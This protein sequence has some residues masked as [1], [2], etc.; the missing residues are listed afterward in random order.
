MH[1]L[2]PR[3][4]HEDLEH[5]TRLRQRRYL[6]RVEL[7]RQEAA[8]R[9]LCVARADPGAPEVRAQRRLD[10]RQ[11]LTQHAVLA[12]V[13]HLVERLLDGAYLTGCRRVIALSG[14]EAQ[15]EQACQHACDARVRRQ[16]GLDVRLRQREPDLPQVLRVGAQDRDLV[17]SEPCLQDQSVEVVVLDAALEHARKRVFEQRREGPDI[18]LV[19]CRHVELEVVN[20]HRFGAVGRDCVGPF[21]QHAHAHVLEHRQRIRQRHR[22]TAAVDLEAET[23]G[24]ASS[25]SIEVEHELGACQALESLYI[26][27]GADRV[28]MFAVGRRECG[29]VAPQKLRGVHLLDRSFRAERRSSSQRRAVAASCASSARRSYDRDASRSRAHG[30]VDARQY[31]RRS[32]ARR[33]RPRSR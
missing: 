18:D 16:R 33:I 22:R 27:D 7:E 31:R 15:P 1:A 23:V 28:D 29:S 13:R 3:G 4:V 6:L 8:T 11:Q 19:A 21:G 9:T 17:G 26:L 12:R 10:Q 32:A 30:D 5:R 25:R 24:R 2:E 14:I 20:P